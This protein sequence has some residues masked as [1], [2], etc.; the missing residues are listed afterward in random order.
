MIHNKEVHTAMGLLGHVAGC[1]RLTELLLDKSPA[2]HSAFPALRFGDGDT[3]LYE[4]ADD[5][6][7]ISL[8][9]TIG[10]TARASEFLIPGNMGVG[11]KTPGVDI[12]GGTADLTGIIFE[13]EN[14][15]GIASAV[16][17]GNFAQ[18]VMS[19]RGGGADDKSITLA[20]DAGEASFSSVTDAGA[21][22]VANIL[23]MDLGTGDVTLAS[24]LLLTTIKSGATQVAAGAAA[25]E[26][27]KT[28]SHASLPDNV[29]MIG[30]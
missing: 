13:V 3:G 29:L 28:S 25:N 1:A 14:A 6:L 21:Y 19:D 26:V 9:G 18:F 24:S 11:T 22:R 8:G 10:A 7:C 16:I 20:V 5:T 2:D 17:D 27:W 4:A 15:A 12:G 23:K 30:V